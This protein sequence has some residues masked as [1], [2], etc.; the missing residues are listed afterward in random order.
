VVRPRPQG[1]TK[2]CLQKQ[3]GLPLDTDSETL[4]KK[5]GF[6]PVT[7]DRRNVDVRLPISPINANDDG[8]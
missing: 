1:S 4:K 7:S 5:G 3:P 6:S 8:L 2:K